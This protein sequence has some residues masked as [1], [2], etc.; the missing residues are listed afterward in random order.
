MSKKTPAWK[1][2]GD[3]SRE[4]YLIN[5]ILFTEWIVRHNQKAQ[6][7]EKQKKAGRGNKDV[8]RRSTE[9]LDEIIA[10]NPKSFDELLKL[11]KNHDSIYEVD[12]DRQQYTFIKKDGG[13]SAPVSFDSIETYLTSK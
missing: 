6:P 8:K 11:L 12:H 9:I 4:D 13:V 2:S 10:L 7:K 1:F 3:M 5:R